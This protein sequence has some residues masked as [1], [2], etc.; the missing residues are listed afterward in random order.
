[1]GDGEQRR[2]HLSAGHYVK[3]VTADSALQESVTLIAA[4]FGFPAVVVNIV[5]A[6]TRHTIAA[7]GAPLGTAPRVST[8]CDHTVR[9]GVPVVH[10]EVT[11][12]P[13]SSPHLQAYV[14]VPLT[15]REGIVVGTL[16]LLDTRPRHF[17]AERMVQLVAIA[18]VVEDQL[19]MLRRRGPHPV[20]ST[21]NVTELTAAVDAD[22][23]VPY[24]QPIV[25]L[26]TG[27]IMGVEALA[28]WHHPVRG[29]LP[30][31]TFIPLAEDTEI[32]IDLDLAILSQA[33][34][35]FVGWQR[36][37]P[38][39]RLNTN[40]S[41]RHFEHHDCVDRITGAVTTAGL[42]P[43]VVNVE[44][45]ETAE[46]ATASHDAHRFL[47]TLRARGF[48]IVL[49][50]FGTE[51]SAMKHLLCLPVDGLK[52]DH[53]FTAALGTPVGDALIRGVVGFA[54]ELDLT[55]V[56]EGVE[57]QHQATR[58]HHL[59][60][61]LAQ[62]YLWAPPLPATQLAELLNT[63][64]MTPPYPTTKRRYPVL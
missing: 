13:A 29:V 4:N 19:E 6:D 22:Q 5:D 53:S 16:C 3:V 61:T 48:R 58:A 30:P 43:E 63:T 47:D 9:N 60:A 33:A 54:A 2:Q 40:L 24:Y 10:S 21:T 56:I 20:G 28:R 36:Q 31:A 15:G 42:A 8:L 55:L 11:T 18:A 26:R 50:D 64:F 52:T 7:V 14:G 34:V 49:D 23:I 27:Q 1:M 62:G 46:I 59:G 12:P 35:D 37:Y 44:V 51:Y 39:L 25:D 32:I 45:T 17:S 57:T 38:R 41:S